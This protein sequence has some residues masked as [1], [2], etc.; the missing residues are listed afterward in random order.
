LKTLQSHKLNE[1]LQ[2]A[3]MYK[4]AN[5][6]QLLARKTLSGTADGLHN[7]AFNSD[8]FQFSQFR[9]Y[10]NGDDVRLIDWKTFA[11][12]DKFFIKQS[13]AQQQ[14]N[15]RIIPD[16][17]ESMQYEEQGISKLNCMQF[18]M[19][20]LANIAANQN[21][22]LFYF[23]ERKSIDLAHFKKKVM[24]LQ[25]SGTW[26]QAQENYKAV[27]AKGGKSIIIY[28]TDLYEYNNE[29]LNWLKRLQAMQHEIIVFQIM[30]KRELALNFNNKTTLKDLENNETVTLTNTNKKQLQK[31]YTS[32][33]QKIYQT[34]QKNK[35]ALQQIF[36]G[37]SP[38]AQINHFLKFRNLFR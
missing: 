3:S 1:W 11:K 19:F 15:F 9:N 20:V 24:H 32:A 36:L 31:N 16:V 30:G 37:E 14:L 8:D 4:T 28:L 34:L 35:I 2:K 13:T 27:Q 5:G 6:L 10:T 25:L 33:Q 26:L 18:L 22:R 7:T 12:S 17:S 38:I 21:D 23:D 29:M